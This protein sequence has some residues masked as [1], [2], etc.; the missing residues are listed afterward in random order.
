MIVLKRMVLAYAFL[1]INFLYPCLALAADYEKEI[2]KLFAL[3][4]EKI[5]VGMA[6]LIIAKEIYPYLDIKAYSAKIDTLAANVR[7]L[8]KG[9]L[10]PDW[11]V[12]VLNTYLFRTEGFRYD[13]DDVYV[14]KRDNR[15]LNGILDTKKGSCVTLPLLYLSVAQRLGYPVYAVSAPMHYFL[16]YADPKFKEQNIEATSGGGYNPDEEYIAVLQ[17]SKTAL[18]SG[19][20]M[21][22]MSHKEFLADLLAQNATYWARKG[23]IKRSVRYLEKC[24]K[25]KPK[26]A[27]IVKVLGIAYNDYSIMAAESEAEAEEYRMKS[28][29]YIRKAHEMGVTSISNEDYVNVQ[30]KAQADFRKRNNLGGKK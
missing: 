14:T 6:A 19:A 28:E 23:D 3:P 1:L 29:R 21:R 30:T 12:R 11:R 16:R 2:D 27:D 7:L 25:L 17:I 9:S 20:Y 15:Y 22:T 10:D 8:T 26:S 13:K 5:D 18:K 4:E 24:N